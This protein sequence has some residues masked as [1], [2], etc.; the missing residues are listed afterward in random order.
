MFWSSGLSSHLA[1]VTP[2]ADNPFMDTEKTALLFGPYKT[3][4]L[5]VGDHA[6]AF[7]VMPKW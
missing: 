2:I 5:K 6:F 1:D 4:P 7:T 3:P